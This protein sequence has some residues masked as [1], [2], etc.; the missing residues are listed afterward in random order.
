MP[1]TKTVLFPPPLR[2]AN[3]IQDIQNWLFSIQ[4]LMPLALVDTSGGSY[5]EAVPP[6]GLNI[7]TGQS[8]QNQQIL[9][10]KTSA[11]ANVFTL[12][13]CAN[14]SQTL[15]AAFSAV[16]IKSDGTNWWGVPLGSSGGGG[17]GAVWGSITGNINSQTDLQAEFAALQAQIPIFVD[18]ETPVGAVDGSNTSFD[19]LSAPNPPDSLKLEVDG[20]WP[21]YAVDYTLG[22][23]NPTSIKLNDPP[24]RIIRAH[25]RR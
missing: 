2:A 12:T 1:T 17:G 14:G 11:D 18:N 25:Y 19:L 22:F 8:N 4:N 21:T 24:Q 9:Y 20:L 5:S 15:T 7:S 6:A 16:L 13:G 3:T 23:P 10:I